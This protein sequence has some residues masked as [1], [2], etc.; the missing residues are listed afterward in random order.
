M[1]T[2]KT[3]QNRY[4]T[5]EHL[6]DDRSTLPRG[7][8]ATLQQ[9]PPQLWRRIRLCE[10]EGNGTPGR[11]R[12]PHP[13]EFTIEVLS[14]D[15]VCHHLGQPPAA[16]SNATRNTQQ[17]LF[18]CKGAGDGDAFGRCMHHC[19]RGRKTQG[20]RFEGITKRQAKSAFDELNEL[21]T[22]QLKKEGTLRL[23]GLGVFRK[24]KLKARVGRN[25][26]TGEQTSRLFTTAAHSGTG[27][28][29]FSRSGPRSSKIVVAKGLSCVAPSS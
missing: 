14:E 11:S 4:R 6:R 15:R 16:G 5:S 22:R 26:A 24:R 13:A 21:V 2:L 1:F 10:Q 29:S 27:F 19:A 3:E 7:S 17:F 25:P 8:F 23:A 28:G 20:A 9:V 12:P 18:C